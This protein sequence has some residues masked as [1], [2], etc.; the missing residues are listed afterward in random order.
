VAGIPNHLIIESDAPYSDQAMAIGIQP[1]DRK[2]LKKYLSRY[3]LLK[4][5][6]RK[7]Q[8]ESSL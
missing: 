1:G 3:P 2:R 8:K 7:Q 5:G 4:D 6:D